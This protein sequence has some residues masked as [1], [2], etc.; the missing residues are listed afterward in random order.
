M[1]L[2]FVPFAETKFMNYALSV[3]LINIPNH[4]LNVHW[5]GEYAIISFIFIAS[6]DGSKREEHVQWTTKNGNFKNSTNYNDYTHSYAFNPNQFATIT[7]H[8]KF[9]NI[10]SISFIFI[11]FCSVFVY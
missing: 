3:K 7:Y 5:L 10:L 8:Y 9:D 1:G 2:M 4:L 11:F 6:H